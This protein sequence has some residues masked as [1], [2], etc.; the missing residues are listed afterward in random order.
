MRPLFLRN[1][2]VRCLGVPR[3]NNTRHAGAEGLAVRPDS[4][5]PLQCLSVDFDLDGGTLSPPDWEDIQGLRLAR[6]RTLP[7][8]RARAAARSAPGPA[9]CP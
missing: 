2:V 4:E 9:A 7:R 3:R 1:L 5:G 8:A 6:G